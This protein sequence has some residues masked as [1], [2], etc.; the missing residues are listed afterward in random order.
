MLRSKASRTD[1]DMKV[2]LLDK[3]LAASWKPLLASTPVEEQHFNNDQIEAM[4][5]WVSAMMKAL[6]SPPTGM[7][8]RD[9]SSFW[10][11]IRECHDKAK[12]L[13]VNGRAA[14]VQPKLLRFMPVIFGVANG[15]SEARAFWDRGTDDYFFLVPEAEVH[16]ACAKCE[17]CMKE[18]YG[19]LDIAAADAHA[20]MATLDC[21]SLGGGSPRC[22]TPW[23]RSKSHVRRCSRP[24]SLPALSPAASSMTFTCTSSLCALR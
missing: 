12:H 24:S 18:Q 5:T 20:V 6:L 19:D 9:W 13:L 14:L 21:A 16:A 22:S 17:D 10:N 3:L 15:S 11:K 2:D 8:G 7:G 23:R 1:R 4:V